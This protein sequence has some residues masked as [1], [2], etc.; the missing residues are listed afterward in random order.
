M[1]P[2]AVSLTAV[3]SRLP[4]LGLWG[5]NQRIRVLLPPASQINDFLKQ[6]FIQSK[7]DI[8]INMKTLLK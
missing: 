8:A 6:V 2:A 3:F 5:V 7:D 4:I 1:D